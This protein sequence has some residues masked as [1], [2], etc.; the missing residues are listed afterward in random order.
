MIKL[1]SKNIKDVYLGGKKIAKMYLGSKLVYDSGPP[2]GFWITVSNTPN[3]EIPID[4]KS[5]SLTLN[6]NEP[7]FVKVPRSTK[8]FLYMFKNQHYITALDFSPLDT[9]NIQ[10]MDG[11]FA[12]S[13]VKSLDLSAFDTSSL[14]S[15]SDMFNSMTMLDTLDLSNFDMSKV[16]YMSN[17]FLGT[18]HIKHIKCREA[19]KDWCLANQSKIALTSNIKNYP[20]FWEIVG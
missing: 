6:L 20:D 10:K 1:G 7:T 13:T 8:S 5:V 15:V 3:R 2:N 16:T 18:S 17:M 12:Q 4:N 14:V 19:F 9:S 11:M